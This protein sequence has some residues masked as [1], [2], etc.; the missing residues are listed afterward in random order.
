MSAISMS[1]NE[2]SKVNAADRLSKHLKKVLT[3]DMLKKRIYLRYVA[4]GRAT[5]TDDEAASATPESAR[6]QTWGQ[7]ID[8]DGSMDGLVC[9]LLLEEESGEDGMIRVSV[10]QAH[11]FCGTPET[12]LKNVEKGESLADV[13]VS[14]NLSLGEQARRVTDFVE[15]VL[16]EMTKVYNYN[17]RALHLEKAELLPA[18]LAW[19][20]KVIDAWNKNNSKPVVQEQKSSHDHYDS[21]FDPTDPYDSDYYP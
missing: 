5:L 20:W 3:H 8:H 6:Q 7:V 16:A 15:P 11:D 9:K 14:K 10:I 2:Q 13:W 21:D 18:E 1:C 12:T 17:R 19:M 4:Y